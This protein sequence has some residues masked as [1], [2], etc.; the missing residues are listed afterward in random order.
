MEI[1]VWQHL[2]R[3]MACPAR[4]W[5]AFSP[6]MFLAGDGGGLIFLLKPRMHPQEFLALVHHAH[7]TAAAGVFGFQDGRNS[8]D[9]TH[10]PLPLNSRLLAP[11]TWR[12]GIWGC[13]A[14]HA[15][16]QEGGGRGLILLLK[17]RMHPQKFLAFCSSGALEAVVFCI[18]S[19]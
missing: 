7:E 17:H 12:G 19:R 9:A 5:R 3:P 1:N 18:R 16:W 6:R 8:W 10:Q 11:R 14:C 15:F 4:F 2:F 13:F